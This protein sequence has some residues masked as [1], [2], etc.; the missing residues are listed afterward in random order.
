MDMKQRLDMISGPAGVLETP[1]TDH[2]TTATLAG[3]PAMPRE[4]TIAAA[5]NQAAVAD[6]AATILSG[7]FSRTRALSGPGAAARPS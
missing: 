7:T 3:E 6:E 1:P 2:F 4:S 5:R